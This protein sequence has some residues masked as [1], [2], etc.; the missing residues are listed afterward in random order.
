MILSKEGIHSTVMY[1]MS[2]LC[3]DLCQALGIA[4][5]PNIVR[6]FPLWRLYVSWE[7]GKYYTS[8]VTYNSG[9]QRI[10]KAVIT[11]LSILGSCLYIT[12]VLH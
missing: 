9:Q 8:K 4:A 3:Q 12:C 1:C 7:E 10:L 6:V 2:T 11:Q 5:E